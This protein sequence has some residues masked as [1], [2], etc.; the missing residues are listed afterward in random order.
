MLF[1]WNVIFLKTDWQ[2]LGKIVCSKSRAIRSKLDFLR[3]GESWDEEEIFSLICLI[4]S[5]KNVSHIA[6]DSM[7][8][9]PTEGFNS[10]I[11]SGKKLHLDSDN[12]PT[13]RSLRSCNQL[14]FSVPPS[15]CKSKGDRAFTVAAPKLWNS[16]PFNISASPSLNVLN[17]V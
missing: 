12:S 1:L 9:R 13:S 16:L 6:R 15:H 5:T 2:I 14:L 7:G 10:T 11:Y 17:L 3:S 8:K 4:I